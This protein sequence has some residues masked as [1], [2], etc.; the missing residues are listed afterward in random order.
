VG[1]RGLELALMTLGRLTIVPLRFTSLNG[2]PDHL[3]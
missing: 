3:R 2:H 1:R